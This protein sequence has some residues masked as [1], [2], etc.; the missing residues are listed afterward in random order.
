MAS[1]SQTYY[2]INASLLL[3]Q[4]KPEHPV[5]I[6]NRLN[7]FFSDESEFTPYLYNV[8]CSLRNGYIV[9]IA[10]SLIQNNQLLPKLLP[11]LYLLIALNSLSRAKKIIPVFSRTIGA[12]P[13]N[14]TTI[15]AYFEQQGLP[16]IAFPF[17]SID[18]KIDKQNIN[19][20]CLLTLSSNPTD[21]TKIYQENTG[22]TFTI[23]S[24]SETI[25]D[26]SV[27][28]DIRH[29]LSFSK[30]PNE[31]DF[32][33]VITN[34]IEKGEF[35][36]ERQLWRKRT[37]LYQDFL[38]VGKMVQQKEY[39]DVINWYHKEYEILPRWY[40]RFGHILKVITGKRTFRSLFRDDVKKYKD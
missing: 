24:F 10:D 16:D 23:I 39:Y 17:F 34:Y 8:L 4:F 14:T 11:K 21:L 38:I 15:K 6:N 13:W 31:F 36:T 5:F 29:Q 26:L 18:P 19:G 37:L 25:T 7:I 22:N 2:T 3:E 32:N 35:E 40:K 28:E 30:P 33:E 12:D 1:S 27:I 9:S 20:C